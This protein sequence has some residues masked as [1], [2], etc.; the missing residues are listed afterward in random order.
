MLKKT[1]L[2]ASKF[3][4]ANFGRG[5]N[6]CLCGNLSRLDIHIKS[7]ETALKD[8]KACKVCGGGGYSICGVCG[9]PLHFIPTKG[10]HAGKL[11][12]LIITMT[13]FFIRSR[14]F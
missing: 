3:K 5:E 2:E 13:L 6:F 1:A 12:F 11:C 9:V 4:K 14:L 7:V 8:P 10:K